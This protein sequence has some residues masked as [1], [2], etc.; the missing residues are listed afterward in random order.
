[1]IRTSLSLAARVCHGA[2]HIVDGQIA[3]LKTAVRI[4]F[5]DPLPAQVRHFAPIARL[6]DE[7]NRLVTG[8]QW[9][10]I[11]DTKRNAVNR[12]A[13]DIE[14]QVIAGYA[15]AFQGLTNTDLRVGHDQHISEL[16]ALIVRADALHEGDDDTAGAASS[17]TEVNW[18][19]TIG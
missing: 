14:R 8:L 6:V 9:L 17:R 1:M 3:A 12:A 10:Q 2:T 16:I 19:A 5:H 4:D 7:E 15:G 11:G 13:L 18:C